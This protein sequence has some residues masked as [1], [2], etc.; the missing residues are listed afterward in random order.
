MEGW[1]IKNQQQ[2]DAFVAWI[3]D[4]L[5][6]GKEIRYEVHKP[7][8]RTKR[9]NRALHAGFTLLAQALNDSGMDMLSFPWTEGI[10]VPWSKD[11]V[12]S[13]LYTPVLEAQL[14]GKQKTSQLAKTEVSQVWDTL[15]RHLA[16][17]IGVSVPFP[18]FD[19][20]YAQARP[21]KG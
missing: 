16:T 14:E 19:H 10:D 21:P 4:Q 15:T 7:E 1:L 9:Q 20:I 13:H 6:H 12:K 5:S 3:D 17:R 8:T 2:R 11:T 18:S